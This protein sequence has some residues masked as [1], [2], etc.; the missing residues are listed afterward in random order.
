M[1]HPGSRAGLAAVVLFALAGCAAMPT[2]MLE[3]HTML[4]SV[5]PAGGSTG[6]EVGTTVTIQFSHR[7]GAGMERYVALHEGDVAGP[8]VSGTWSWAAD[9]TVLTFTPAAEL[10]GQ[11]RYTLHLGGRM[12]DATGHAIG[13]GQHGSHMGGEWTGGGM[14]GGGGMTGSG[15]MMSTG[16]GHMGSGWQHANGSHGM[17]FSFTTA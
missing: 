11:T 6:V 7:M 13:F 8:V 12:I 2:A 10:K 4:T 9:R 14:M 15:G 3:G 5:I 1:N 16:S 17:V